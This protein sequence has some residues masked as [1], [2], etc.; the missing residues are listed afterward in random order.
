M[1]VITSLSNQLVKEIKSL[2]SKKGRDNLNAFIIEGA[3][4]VQEAIKDNLKIRSLAIIEHYQPDKYILDNIKEYTIFSE[5]VFKKICTTDT[6]ANIL[7]VVEKKSF[8]MDEIVNKPNSNKLIAVLDEIKDPGNLG[9]IIRTCCAAEVDGIILTDL[10]VDMY[11]PKVIRSTAGA[12]WKLPVIYFNDKQKLIEV[13]KSN[14]VKV[15]AADMSAEEDYC[16]VDYTKNVAI[17]LGSEA[18][19][20]SKC[21]L[22][23]S[24]KA[25]KIPISAKV[26]SLNVAS[27]AAI[28]LFEALRQRSFLT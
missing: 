27:S 19:G 1:T 3:K 10:S 13:L 18:A 7:A 2:H 24:D 15:Y 26:E 4:I 8:S 9:T 16:S 11:N 14:D 17:I 5:N 20:I 28:I 25:I 22:E 12:L 23:L 21:F 6:P